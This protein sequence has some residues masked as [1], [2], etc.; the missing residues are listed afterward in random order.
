M[1]T[2]SVKWIG[3]ADQYLRNVPTILVGCK[4]DM[5]DNVQAFGEHRREGTEPISPY[6]VGS[7][8]CSSRST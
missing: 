1:I 6:K 7:Y 8:Q 5:R 4:K 2:D 3:E